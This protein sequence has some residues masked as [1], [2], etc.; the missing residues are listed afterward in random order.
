L[1]RD[2]PIPSPNNNVWSKRRTVYEQKKIP[3]AAL[4]NQCQGRNFSGETA[5]KPSKFWLCR[6]SPE[7]RRHCIEKEGSIW[8]TPRCS[9][10]A[11]GPIRWIE[12]RVCGVVLSRNRN[13]V[14]HPGLRAFRV[15][16]TYPSNFTTRIPLEFLEPKL[17]HRS[18]ITKDLLLSGGLTCLE[19]LSA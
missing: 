10:S 18:K 14:C 12:P 1:R 6:G 16:L 8:V 9:V 11:T 3:L 2:N 17:S 4:G 7:L 5:A 19:I 15:L 13:K